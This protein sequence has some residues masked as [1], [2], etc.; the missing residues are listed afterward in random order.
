MI[1]QLP[2]D[3]ERLAQSYTDR[4]HKPLYGVEEAP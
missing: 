1:H 2:A 3:A 4:G